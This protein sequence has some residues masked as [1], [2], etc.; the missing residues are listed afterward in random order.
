MINPHGN[1][2]LHRVKKRLDELISELDQLVKDEHR[3]TQSAA[4]HDA[5]GDDAAWV[6]IIAEQR[7][8]LAAVAA[9]IADSIGNSA[10]S[11][12][13]TASRTHMWQALP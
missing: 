13:V 11:R 6:R 9:I 4:V 3:S 7:D 12:L 1:K 5:P 10:Y 2:K 8:V